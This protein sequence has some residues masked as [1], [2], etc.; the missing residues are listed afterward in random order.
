MS[1]TRLEKRPQLFQINATDNPNKPGTKGGFVMENTITN[2][3][4]QGK[5]IGFDETFTQVKS[6]K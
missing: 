6:G 2:A 1:K 3:M 4:L 5:A